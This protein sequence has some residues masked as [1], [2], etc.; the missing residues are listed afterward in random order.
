MQR[1]GRPSRSN[2]TF[3]N[4][5]FVRANVVLYGGRKKN[6]SSDISRPFFRTPGTAAISVCG[7]GV[8]G[9]RYHYNRKSFYV[10]TPLCT[11]YRTTGQ[12][13]APERSRAAFVPASAIARIE[14]ES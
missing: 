12:H 1:T 5:T 11:K 13:F 10:S 14:A 3:V 8:V 2:A 7:T 4:A 9:G 6:A